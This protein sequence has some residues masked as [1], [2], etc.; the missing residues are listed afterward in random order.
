[1]LD[2]ARKVPTLNFLG[3]SN[4]SAS[5]FTDVELTIDVPSGFDAIRHKFLTREWRGGLELAH[6][7]IRLRV[8]P[9]LATGTFGHS[10]DDVG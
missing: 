4:S 8:L 6:E 9:I 1:M 5:N 3:F 7:I 10:D 2:P